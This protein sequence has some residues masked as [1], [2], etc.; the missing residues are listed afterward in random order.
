MVLPFYEYF[1][2]NSSFLD[3]ALQYNISNQTF[4]FLNSIAGGGS[5]TIVAI[6]IDEHVIALL[7]APGDF[8]EKICVRESPGDSLNR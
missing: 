5:G 3:F 4:R 6:S 8:E 1:T 7:G 2:L